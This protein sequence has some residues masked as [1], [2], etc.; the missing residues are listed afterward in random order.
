MTTFIIKY[1]G[2]NKDGDLVEATPDIAHVFRVF[3]CVENSKKLVHDF[4]MLSK[5]NQFI[6]NIQE[7]E[8]NID[9][10]LA[11]IVA[12]R[13]EI[14]PELIEKVLETIKQDIIRRAL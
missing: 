1:Y 13:Q 5:A 6:K 8:R 11:A 3:Q 4:S 14:H 7:A 9:N 2:S 10:A 12:G